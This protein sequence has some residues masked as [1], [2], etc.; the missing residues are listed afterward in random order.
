[1]AEYAFKHPLTQEVALS[2]QLRERRRQVHAAVAGAIE[3][4]YAEHLDERA[5]L[6][7]HHYEEA[8]EALSAARWH[9]R[10]ADWAGRTDFAAA[11]HHW[12]RVRE[13]LRELPD[14]REA[15]V[16]GIAACMQLLNVSWR[17]G[18]GLEEARALLEEGQTL[19]NAI[20]DR[21][22]HLY[23]SMVYG[24]ARCGAGDTAEYLELAIG[25]QSAALQIGD[26]G[27]QANACYYLVDALSWAGRLPDALQA[28][29]EGLARFPR[30]LPSEEWLA[31]INPY[32]AF[33]FWRAT[34][35]TWAGSLREGLE[36][37]GRCL[38][39]EDGTPEV[40]GYALFTTAEAYYHV[41]DADRAI[42]S[43]RQVEEISRTLG[44]PAGLVAYAQLAFSFAHLAAGR[45]ADA[46]DSARAALDLFKGV[47]KASAGLSTTLLAEAAAVLSD[48]AT[49]LL[50][51]AQQ[52]YVEIGAPAQAERLAK[53]Q[54]A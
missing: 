26:V 29:E 17:V 15:A 41:H 27:V 22:A 16:L 37:L 36:E 49:R 23:L 43:A 47:D 44:E 42:A 52:A 28:A 10:A 54:R 4:Q 48:N 35:L 20:G 3:L 2:S 38:A 40:A 45:A 34:C 50:R 6:L 31:G 33:L 8:G 19:A 39:E 11:T 18:T 32:S 30:H 1:V 12:E 9:R 46:I 5:A 53:E 51:Q 7:A 14:D 21:R 24:R 13:L 25:N